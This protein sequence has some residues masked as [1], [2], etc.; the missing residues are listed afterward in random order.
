MAAG[1]TIAPVSRANARRAAKI[2]CNASGFDAVLEDAQHDCA[3]K[4]ENNIRGDDAQLADEGTCVVHSDISQSLGRFRSR[5]ARAG[6]HSRRRLS[7]KVS[8]AV[9]RD[10]GALT[11]AR[12]ALALKMRDARPEPRPHG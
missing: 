6:Q 10:W 9:P 11:F 8:P 12:S 4:G 7:E 1:N 3:H 5:S 2:R